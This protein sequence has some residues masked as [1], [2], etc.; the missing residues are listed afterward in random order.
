MS[1]SIRT[2]LSDKNLKYGI[3]KVFLGFFDSLTLGYLRRS[4]ILKAKFITSDTFS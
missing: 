4:A 2:Y 3:F 1:F